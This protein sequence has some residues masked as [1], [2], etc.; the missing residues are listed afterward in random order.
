MALK[1]NQQFIESLIPQLKLFKSYFKFSD[2]NLKRIIEAMKKVDR[3]IFVPEV[4][5]PYIDAPLPIGHR[6]TCSQPSLVMFFPL[7]LGL[8]PGQKVLEIGTG[9]GYHAALTHRLISPQ[10]KLTTIEIIP[11]LSLA[12]RKNLKKSNQDLGIK[13]IDFIAGDGSQGYQ[14]N[15][16]YDAIYFTA[17]VEGGEA[18]LN[19][20]P[21]IK[22]LKPQGKILYPQ[23]QG[24]LTLGTKKKSRLEKKPLMFVSFVP[25]KQRN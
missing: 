24:P 4:P 17:G 11:S 3:R 12:A 18:G 14:K 10:G 19:L 8:K 13:N 25:L 2:K 21:L 1:K 5:I 22:Q 15:A 20:E 9:C 23:A 16:P 7:V 6:Q